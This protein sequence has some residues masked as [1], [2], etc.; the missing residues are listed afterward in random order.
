M[1][2]MMFGRLDAYRR[3]ARLDR[4]IGTLLL[5]W[6]TLTALWL[7]ASGWPQW[8]L[9]LVFFVGVW[10]MRASGCIINDYAD[11]HVDG[12]VSRTQQRPLA[13]GEI[14]SWEALVLFGILAL[15]CFLLVLQLNR[16][17][18]QL[19]WIGIALTIIYPFT[20][21]FLA[22]PQMF[23]GI[24]WSWCIPMA[25]AAQ[26]GH[27]PLYAWL[28]FVANWCWTVAYDTMYGMVDRDDDIRIGI[29]SSAIWFGRWDRCFIGL[30]QV[31]TLF[32][33]ALIG[34]LQQLSLSYFVALGIIG[35]LFGY[36]QGLLASGERTQYFRAFLNNNWAGAVLFWGVFVHFI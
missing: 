6:P 28:L 15:L 10:L 14:H 7:A 16:L 35:L 4:P 36:Q 21:R 12:Q 29:R 32:C 18:M 11:R 3:L 1:L 17:S 27:V 20:K 9:F 8:D 2:T 5:M 19:A 26:S 33:L 30:F 34:H 13:Q 23:L 25:F 24:V 31:I 22:A